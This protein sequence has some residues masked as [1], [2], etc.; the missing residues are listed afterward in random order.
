MSW[1][2]LLSRPFPFGATCCIDSMRVCSRIALK[3]ELRLR[4]TGRGVHLPEA[5]LWGPVEYSWWYPIERRLC[6]LKCYVRN[7]AW[8]EGW[9]A[10]AYVANEC[11]TFSSKH[12]DDLQTIFNQ[13]PRNQ[14]FSNEEAYHVDFFLATVL[15]LLLYQILHLYMLKMALIIRCEYVLKNC[16]QVEKCVKYA[17]TCILFLIFV[18]YILGVLTCFCSQNVQR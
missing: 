5:L 9:I 15:I 16:S 7:R 14:G 10:K 1:F 2:V 3:S 8:Q 18:L 13:Q 17:M 4:A 12:M 6:T 11:M